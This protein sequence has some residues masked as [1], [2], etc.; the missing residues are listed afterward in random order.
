MKTFL[1][2]AVLCVKNVCVCVC[3][4]VCVWVS[5]LAIN[6]HGFLSK[7]SAVPPDIRSLCTAAQQLKTVCLDIS[8]AAFRSPGYLRSPDQQPP[9]SPPASHSTPSWQ[10]DTV[11]KEIRC[12]TILNCLWIKRRHSTSS[13]RGW[14]RMQWE[15]AIWFSHGTH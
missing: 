3:M 8:S 15:G 7:R 4:C 6:P 1:G 2:L 9:R 12:L 10:Y 11:S 13:V 5:K 14:R